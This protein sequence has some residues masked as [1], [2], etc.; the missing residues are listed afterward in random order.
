MYS[1]GGNGSGLWGRRMRRSENGRMEI[2]KGDYGL[3]DDF[4]CNDLAWPTPYGEA[5]NDHDAGLFEGGF[6]VGHAV[7]ENVS[8]YSRMHGGGQVL[9]YGSKGML[10]EILRRGRG[11]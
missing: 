8:C 4:R 6:I 7:W 2:A 5:V 3:L 10:K 9:C 1:G 11:T